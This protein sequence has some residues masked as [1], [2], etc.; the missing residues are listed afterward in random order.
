[1]NWWILKELR[2]IVLTDLKMYVPEAYFEGNVSSLKLHDAIQNHEHLSSELTWGSLAGQ[3]G[4]SLY[5]KKSSGLSARETAASFLLLNLGSYTCA[6][7]SQSAVKDLLSKGIH[8]DSLFAVNSQFKNEIIPQFEKNLSVSLIQYLKYLDSNEAKPFLQ[9][10]E[11]I[12][13]DKSAINKQ[14]KTSHDV[15]SEGLTNNVYING[16]LIGS[17]E[18]INKLISTSYEDKPR[19][20]FLQYLIKRMIEIIV[21]VVVALVVAFLTQCYL[22]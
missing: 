1:M 4:L 2:A 22:S 3:L 7:A 12:T 13:D 10:V 16:D 17:L 5:F 15:V 21:G 8:D 9:L 11:D 20:K 6:I 14:N 19:N 18:L